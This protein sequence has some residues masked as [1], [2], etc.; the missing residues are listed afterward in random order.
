[1]IRATRMPE[2]FPKIYKEW[3]MG[4]VLAGVLAGREVIF[5]SFFIFFLGKGYMLS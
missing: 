1:M 2:V 4:N 5:F 3:K